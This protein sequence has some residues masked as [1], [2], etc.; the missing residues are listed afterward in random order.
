[1][2]T[3]DVR[4]TTIFPMLLEIA[5]LDWMNLDELGTDKAQLNDS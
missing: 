3:A 1:M 4:E 5:K 2:N